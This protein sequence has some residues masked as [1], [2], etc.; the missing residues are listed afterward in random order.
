M[1]NGVSAGVTATY[2]DG[3]YGSYPGAAVSYPPGLGGNQ[4]VSIDATGKEI[5]RTPR[6]TFGVSLGYDMVVAGGDLS[7]SAN[8]FYS[9]GL[10]F[11]AAN[12]FRRGHIKCLMRISHGS[13]RVEITRSAW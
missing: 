5:V 4:E 12:I 1:A 2:T 13:R 11:D 9:A 10:Y 7:M 3:Y 6:W 8:L